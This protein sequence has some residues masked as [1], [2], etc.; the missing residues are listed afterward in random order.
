M[1]N[2]VALVGHTSFLVYSCTHP[3]Y[4]FCSILLLAAENIRIH[5]TI[6]S[7][8]NECPISWLT[9]LECT[10]SATCVRWF[11]SHRLEQ[12]LLSRSSQQTSPVVTGQSRQRAGGGG[13]ISGYTGSGKGHCWPEDRFSWPHSL[14]TSV[15]FSWGCIRRGVVNKPILAPVTHGRYAN[16]AGSRLLYS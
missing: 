1:L 8:W 16:D 14:A 2:K 10:Q 9:R 6:T 15:W 4:R 13:V 12:A 7:R 5:L 3:A 11:H